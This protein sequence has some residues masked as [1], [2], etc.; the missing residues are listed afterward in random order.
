VQTTAQCSN[1]R[2]R[3]IVIRGDGKETTATRLKIVGGKEM[4]VSYS[5]SG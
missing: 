2:R 1:G 4:T 3:A 5:R